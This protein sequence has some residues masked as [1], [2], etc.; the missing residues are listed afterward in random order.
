M[1]LR[2]LIVLT[3]NL[4]L[5]GVLVEMILL[6]LRGG[7]LILNMRLRVGKGCCSVRTLREEI[8]G[9]V[10]EEEGGFLDLTDLDWLSLGLIQ[11]RW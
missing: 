7:R 10:L 9:V 1:V 5:L 8:L 2:S 4:D 3:L 11:G 6:N